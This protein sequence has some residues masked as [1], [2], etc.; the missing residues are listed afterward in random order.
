MEMRT[1]EEG[2]AS[3]RRKRVRKTVQNRSRRPKSKNLSRRQFHTIHEERS[4]YR[5]GQW[6][7]QQ[8]M[9][10]LRRLERQQEP[11]QRAHAKTIGQNKSL[12]RSHK[13]KSTWQAEGV[14]RRSNIAYH[15]RRKT[16][17][18]HKGRKK[19]GGPETEGD[20][21]ISCRLQGYEI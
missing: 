9:I 2:G 19:S 11:L 18:L 7:R 4:P 21:E 8:G 1:N 20:T 3:T 5:P 6:H 17:H 14:G 16:F 12:H 15:H 10:R 13:L